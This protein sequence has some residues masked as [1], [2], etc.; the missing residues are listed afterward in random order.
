MRTRHQRL[1][2]LVLSLWLIA[3]SAD[4][5]AQCAMCRD[6]TAGSGPQVRASL[7][8]AIPVLGIPAVLIFVGIFGILFR[9]NKTDKDHSQNCS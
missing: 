3:A 2:K 7:R 1:A 4:A 9:F 8:R 5:S 6:T